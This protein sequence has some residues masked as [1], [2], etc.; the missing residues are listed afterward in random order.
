MVVK[1]QDIPMKWWQSWWIGADY[2]YS[3][4]IA[5]AGLFSGASWAR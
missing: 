1:L 3:G 4:S 2:G 5:A